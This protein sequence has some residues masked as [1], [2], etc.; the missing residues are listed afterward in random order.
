MTT[1]LES[2]LAA[3]RS[4]TFQALDE[5]AETIERE[6]SAVETERDELRESLSRAQIELAREREATR[7]VQG[8][9][10]DA[11]SA[12]TRRLG[13]DW[14]E[15]TLLLASAVIGLGIGYWIQRSLDKRIPWVALGGVGL[16]ATGAVIKTRWSIRGSLIVGG[17]MLAA[18]STVY[19]FTAEGA[20]AL[21]QPEVT[22]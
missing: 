3:E 22:A 10:R 21:S 9:F 2:I 5:D 20:P 4:Y 19:V 13:G 16:V 1:P 12:L 14:K 8:A 17:G 6:R 15:L 7:E 18:G 11:G